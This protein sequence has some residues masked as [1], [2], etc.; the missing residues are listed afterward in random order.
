MRDAAPVECSWTFTTGCYASLR[1]TAGTCGRV[2]GVHRD[3]SVNSLRG[4][5]A[6]KC[7]LALS[8]SGRQ[9]PNH[10]GGDSWQ[11]SVVISARPKACR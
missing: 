1:A 6:L 7:R 10:I 5:L 3:D 4:G 11:D 9:L 8:L 2:P